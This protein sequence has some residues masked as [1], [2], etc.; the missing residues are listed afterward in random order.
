MSRYVGANVKLP[1][2]YNANNTSTRY[3]VIYSQ[4][5]WVGGDSAFASYGDGNWTEAWDS[6]IIPGVNGTAG[7]P[8]PKLILVTF[9]HEAPYYDDSYAVNT[10]NLGP[11]GDA[12]NDELIPYLDKLFNTVAEP[13]AR[14]QEGGSTGG[15]ES[16]ASLIF[17][18]VSCNMFV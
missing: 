8:T 6:G 5:H 12:I 3:P 16:A 4:N 7:R 15:W 9:R 13:Y 10:A 18:P 11:Y 1:H 2:G 14:I 17:R